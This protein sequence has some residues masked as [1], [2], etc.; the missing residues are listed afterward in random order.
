MLNNKPLQGY[1]F[2]DFV[3]FKYNTIVYNQEKGLPMF[4]DVEQYGYLRTTNIWNNKVTVQPISSD[5]HAAG[6]RVESTKIVSKS[7]F[8]GNI[9][10]Y[11]KSAPEGFQVDPPIFSDDPDIPRYP[12]GNM[13]IRP[14]DLT[15][16]DRLIPYNASFDKKTKKAE[17]IAASLD[18]EIEKQKALI[19]GKVSG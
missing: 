12:G 4:R 1:K 16:T 10:D 8:S 5:H 3:K 19:S 11:P 9:E 15:A 14:T 13:P 17:K 18:A 6:M 2:G 7:K